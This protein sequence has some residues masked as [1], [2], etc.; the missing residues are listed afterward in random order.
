MGFREVMASGSDGWQSLLTH[1]IPCEVVSFPIFTEAFCD[2]LLEEIFNF[3]GTGLPARRPNSMNNYG[4]IL[5]DIGLEPFI[6]KLQKLLQPLGRLL[7]P[8][9]GSDWDGH[10]CFIVRYREGEDLGLDMHTDDSD[11]TFN[12]CLG[13]DFEGAGLQ[14]CGDMGSPDHRQHAHTYYH[15]KGTCL[16]HLG[17]RRHGADDITSGERLNLILWS[18]SSTYRLSSEHKKPAYSQET[19]PPAP[20]CVSYTHDRDFGAFKAYPK[21]KEAFQGRGW[22]PPRS[23]EYEGFEEDLPHPAP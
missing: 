11:V 5:S 9:Q 3:Y 17:M 10:H 19:A 15:R 23:A 16:M 20:V 8:G 2:L 4:I 18:Q 21:G 12:L 14:F 1:H 6:N 13:L 7:F 22:C